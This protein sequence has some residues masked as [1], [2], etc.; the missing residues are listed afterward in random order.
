LQ[1]LEL[2][3]ALRAQ[4]AK[5]EEAVHALESERGIAQDRATELEVCD[6]GY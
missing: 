2:S 3:A 4:I 6:A 5:A 1:V